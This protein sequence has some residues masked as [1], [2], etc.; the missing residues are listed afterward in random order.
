M[1]QNRYLSKKINYI[2]ERALRVVYNDSNSNFEELLIKNKSV[3][4]HH[5]NKKQLIIETLIKC[6]NLQLI[7]LGVFNFTE[8]NNFNLRGSINVSTC[9]TNLIVR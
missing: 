9:V 3:T 4:I 6:F 2:H 1:T 5:R 8:N 7:M